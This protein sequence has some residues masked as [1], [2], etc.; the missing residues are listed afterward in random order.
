MWQSSCDPMGGRMG[1]NSAVLGRRF[2]P[3]FQTPKLWGSGMSRRAPAI[4]VLA[5]K[6]SEV[7]QEALITAPIQVQGQEQLTPVEKL[8]MAPF[9]STFCGT[10][11]GAW[12]GVQAAFSPLTGEAEPVG[13]DNKGEPVLDVRTSTLESRE[14][15][16]DDDRVVRRSLRAASA[17]ALRD[18]AAK[19]EWEEEIISSEEDGLVFFDGG[20]YSRGPSSLLAEEVFEGGDLLQADKERLERRLSL[21]ASTLEGSVKDDTAEDEVIRAEA[22]VGDDSA[23]VRRVWLLEQCLAWGGEHRLRLRL[24]LAA[25]PGEKE[26][27]VEVLRIAVLREAWQCLAE[28]DSPACV[29]DPSQVL[30]EVSTGA[31]SQPQDLKGSWKVFDVSASPVPDD[32]SPDEEPGTV[33]VY[34]SSE[35]AQEWGPGRGDPGDCGGA[36]WLPGNALLEL[37]MVPPV[38]RGRAAD[39]QEGMETEGQGRGLCVSFHWLVNE[40]TLIGLQREYSADG[41]LMEVRSRTAVKGGWVGG[42]M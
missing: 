5:S 23:G 21:E 29:A 7:A 26:L 8:Q 42:R 12:Q 38:S 20:T 37:R 2:I 1:Q 9:W 27:E 19:D 40:R 34:F 28:D 14:L 22:D 18:I 16:E 15:E 3:A 33:L 35:T 10:S 32:A 6:K 31:R 17:Q 11:N 36:F 13:L 41:L 24:T 25:F 30:P 39:A 4:R